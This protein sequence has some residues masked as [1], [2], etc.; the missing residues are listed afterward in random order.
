M[1]RDGTGIHLPKVFLFFPPN[2]SS[3]HTSYHNIDNRFRN[4]CGFS[5][6][7]RGPVLGWSRKN[8]RAG[9]RGGVL[10]GAILQTY[11]AI[12]LLNCCTDI[13]TYPCKT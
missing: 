8:V 6:K 11:T 10:W 3:A 1:Q 9:E 13:I 7:D 12:A 2:L 5:S 4:D